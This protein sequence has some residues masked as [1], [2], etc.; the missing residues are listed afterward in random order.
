MERSWLTKEN[1]MKT[2]RIKTDFKE[3]DAGNSEKIKLFIDRVVAD[4]NEITLSFQHCITDYPAT[5]LIIDKLLSQLKALHGRKLLVIQTELDDLPIII[6]NS[7]FH[8][9][10]ELALSDF[11]GLISRDE[12]DNAVNTHLGKEGIG[13]R[14]EKIDFG[15]KVTETYYENNK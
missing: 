14:I 10:K 9:S 15:G 12:I 4:D 5:S 6:L 7:L 1:N 2:I 3:Y 8:G 11:I 13:I